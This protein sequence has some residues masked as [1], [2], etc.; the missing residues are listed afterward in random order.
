MNTTL[1]I[2][3]ETRSRVDLK[4]AG[5][6]RYAR[7]ASTEILLVAWMIGKAT[8]AWDPR[9]E[10]MPDRLR[11]AWA[12]RLVSVMAFGGFDRRVLLEK[13]AALGLAPISDFRW[14]DA[15]A[16][17]LAGGLAVSLEK[18]AKIL[19]LPE[20]ESKIAD[21]KRLIAKFCVPQK[22]GAFIEPGHA[23]LD[24]GDWEAFRRYAVRDV[25]L[26]PRIVE[27]VAPLT[28]F[29][30]QVRR[31]TE[32]M[33]D[34][35]VPLDIAMTAAVDRRFG[36]LAAMAD[37]EVAEL[38]GG[39]A[40][41]SAVR[42]LAWLNAR[43]PEAAR[44]AS[45]SEADAID[46]A[47]LDDVARRVLAARR[48]AA[49]KAPKKAGA[50]L[51]IA[52]PEG[53]EPGVA[54]AFDQFVY[55]GAAM[56]GRWAGRGI[57]P[58]NFPRPTVPPALVAQVVREAILDPQAPL[59]SDAAAAGA[60]VA[61]MT[62]AMRSL[63]WHPAG[64]QWADFSAVELR[65][66][67]V[68]CD[69]FAKAAGIAVRPE[70]DML[71]MLRN[72]VDL[73]VSMGVD[74]AAKLGVSG[75][76]ADNC[77]ATGWRQT[78]KSALLGLGYAMS[79]WRFRTQ[80]TIAGRAMAQHEAETIV[81]AYR[82]KFPLVPALWDWMP[83]ALARVAEEGGRVGLPGV[84]HYE[85]VRRGVVRLVRPGGS[86]LWYHDIRREPVKGKYGPQARL[87]YTGLD[88]MG[89]VTDVTPHAGTL[90]EH[91]VSSLS[92]DLL[93]HAMVEADRAGVELVMTVHD[94]L[95]AVGGVG[96]REKLH[97]AM[98]MLPAWAEGWP[99]D[100]EASGGER[101]GK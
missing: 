53:K 87:R 76:I 2:D 10:P 62:S 94:E 45:L 68:L 78:G 92:R 54:R 9:R 79:A 39:I 12:D 57:Q 40:A 22:N 43:L 21:G 86:S 70:A 30:E 91:W 59:P 8:G 46:A 50:A 27:A 1:Y 97:R 14:R 5:Q 31:V 67:A 99:M 15:Q 3:L 69:A 19:R 98:T 84:G 44:I 56:T 18:C 38:T 41:N 51:A 20:V 25:Q 83:R 6:R 36:A 89:N 74:I 61:A 49:A 24:D 96:V 93:A 29:E 13:G 52:E 60:E 58:Q 90:T 55:C 71:G 80:T 7:D 42:L 47:H 95:V 16:I 11:A 48:V 65:V 66:L 72:R 63:V 100:A 85:R 81:A 101:W 73:Y 35:G 37:S 77:R 75:V 23:L 64:I 33:N 4:K 28:M 82:D 32:K 17:A 34:R 26:L 88:D